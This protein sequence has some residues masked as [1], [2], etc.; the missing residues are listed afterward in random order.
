[1]KNL[2]QNYIKLENITKRAVS[3]AGHSQTLM[4]VGL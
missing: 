4:L 1:M 2:S 3:G